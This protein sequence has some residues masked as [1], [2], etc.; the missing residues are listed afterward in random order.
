[1]DQKRKEKILAMYSTSPAPA[2]GSMHKRT[3]IIFLDCDG[4]ISPFSTG[5]CFA[6]DKMALLKKIVTATNAKIVLSTSWRTTEFGRKE[7][8][9]NLVLNG[10]PMFIDITPDKRAVSRS[11][12]IL[13]WLRLCEEEM[14]VV[15]FV[16]L[17]DINLPAVAPDRD[18]FAR[19]AVVTNGNTGLTEEDVAKAIELLDD[20]NN[21]RTSGEPMM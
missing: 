4:V 14:D 3:K 19:H 17:D 1:M 18:F 6:P 15:N 10:L 20:R 8:G 7:V 13:M 11:Q 2:A 16:A 21:Y 9:K 12:E 5:K